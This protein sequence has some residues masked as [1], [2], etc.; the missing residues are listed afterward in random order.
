MSKKTLNS[1]VGKSEDT[2][3]RLSLSHCLSYCAP[4]VISL[5]L[6]TPMFIIQGIYAKYYGLSLTVLASIIL[7]ARLFDAIT[8]PLIGYYSDRYYR[9][10]GSRKPFILVGG[11]LLIVSS[12][13]L[14]VPTVHE[15]AGSTPTVSLVYFIVW[16][17]AFYLAYTIIEIPH[18]AWASDLAKT[19]A[20]KSKIYSF[21]GAATYIGLLIFYGI[22]L[23][24]FFDTNEIT[25]ET[26]EVSVVLAGLVMLPL[27]LLCITKTPDG[28]TDTNFE[29]VATNLNLP[30]VQKQ[31]WR[32]TVKSIIGN[33]PLL[34]FLSAYV[35]SGFSVGMWQGLVFIYVNSY[36]DMGAQFAQMFLVSLAVGMVAVPVWYKLSIL[37][38]K[39]TV[40]SLGAMLQIASYIY[41]GMLRPGEVGL[42][43]LISLN[44]INS[45]G[46]GSAVVIAPALLSEIIDYGEWKYRLKNTATYYALQTFLNKINAGVG[47]ALGL[48]VAGWYGFDATTTLQSRDGVVGLMLSMVWI[49]C[50]LSL[51]AI[52]LY[53]LNPV[54][55]RRHRIIRRFLDAR[56][57]RESK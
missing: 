33:T 9:R 46:S 27:L 54:N 41:T 4:H 11:L 1:Q 14:Y 53:L 26:L 23:L 18:I 22:P 49:P 57:I 28:Y 50:I 17:F 32:Y 10:T 25:P 2:K 47:A 44:T 15:G 31:D 21:R 43:E 12:Y 51:I 56:A 24:P 7:A 19:A 6:V 16:F 55:T 36:L 13:F 3:N 42:W 37:L 40:L 5:W 52:L 38:G 45:I 39:K 20:D 30:S 34:L 8:D 48:A 29:G 35:I